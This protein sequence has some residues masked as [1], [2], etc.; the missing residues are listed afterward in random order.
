MSKQKQL[1]KDRVQIGKLP[2]K[3]RD[4]DN[5]EAKKI[6]G[7]GGSPGGVLRDHIGEEIPQ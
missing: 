7:G 1:K 5:R 3:Q 4:L 2:Q 6:Q